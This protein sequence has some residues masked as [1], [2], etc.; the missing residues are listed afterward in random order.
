M[1]E[2]FATLFTG[3][4]GADC[5]LQAAGLAHLWGIEKNSGYAAIAQLNGFNVICGD[6]LETAFSELERPD[7]LH[8]SP[9]CQRAS[10]ANSQQGESK[11]D[12]DLANAIC[13][14]I[15]VLRPKLF[16]LENV[17][18]YSEFFAYERIKQTLQRLRYFI[19]AQVCDSAN[20]GV[21]QNR[22]R[23][24]LIASRAITPVFPMPTHEKPG[25]QLSMFSQPWVGW[26]NAFEGDWPNTR[27]EL[28]DR[29]AAMVPQDFTGTALMAGWHQYTGRG[30]AGLTVRRMGQP[31]PCVISK[32]SRP[33]MMPL[34]VQKAG[35][36]VEA[37]QPS[38]KNIAS[39][40]G[41][42]KDY[43]WSE[44][45]VTS[46]EAIGN[47][48]SPPTIKAIALANIKAFSG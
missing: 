19:T 2:T 18:G 20:Y 48:V 42:F 33:S 15:E 39:L 40:Q 47:A 27:Y 21:P 26:D 41:F 38:I 9:P 23:L 5:G 46:L 16:T 44:F 28:S 22:R 32:A 3:A 43:K 7:V 29:M 34:I 12:R 31:A 35:S 13:S 14:A 25:Q 36:S 24:F 10:V 45:D 4:G 30:Q 17:Q 6:V 1:I 8:C 37:Y 11:L